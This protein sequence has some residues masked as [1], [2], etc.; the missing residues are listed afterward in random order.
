VQLE[1]LLLVPGP[2]LALALGPAIE[3]EVAGALEL[4][5]GLTSAAACLWV[6]EE[7]RHVF[8]YPLCPLVLMLAVG[9]LLAVPCKET[10]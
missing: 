4:A 8:P 5:A 3:D 10:G 6:L 1:A 9:L 7:I 2:V